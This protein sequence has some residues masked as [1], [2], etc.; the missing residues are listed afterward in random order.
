MSVGVRAIAYLIDSLLFA[1]GVIIVLYAFDAISVLTNA[2][3]LSY[4]QLVLIAGQCLYFFLWEAAVGW[5]PGKR[6]FQMRVV[7]LDGRPCGVSGSF[8]R[9]LIRPIDV[10]FFGLI[11]ALSIMS[12]FKRQRLGD[13]AAKTQVVREV[14]LPFVP[15]PYVPADK[16]QSRR[17]PRCGALAES[18]QSR[19]AVCDFD[20]DSTPQG[21]WPFG[22]PGFPMPGA[23]Q[24]AAGRRADSARPKPTTA[25]EEDYL[26]EEDQD[27]G[28]QPEAEEP[29]RRQAPPA[30]RPRAAAPAQVPSPFGPSQPAARART[31][32]LVDD[33]YD[34]DSDARLFAGR[35]ILMEGGSDEVRELARAVTEWEAA[36]RH[37]IVN[38]ARTLD[39]FRP[40]MVLEALRNDED[41]EVAAGA[42]DALATVNERTE[43]EEEER[44]AWEEARRTRDDDED[45]DDD[46]VDDDDEDATD[47]EDDEAVVHD[48][49]TGDGD[50]TGEEEVIGDEDEPSAP[51]APEAP[52]APQAPALHDKPTGADKPKRRK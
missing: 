43:R 3:G 29:A 48:D 52:E 27:E 42:R 22:V 20:L 32:G 24:G 25:E 12:G 40:Q 34:D 15:P 47:E 4:T 21:Q 19:C 14:P 10:L 50:V 39:G 38:V 7:R 37:F 46:G 31:A 35:E 13:R 18:G 41:E 6:V 51:P 28:E 30:A 16:P 5:T 26:E 44:L 49:T 11:G 8:V 33:L 1:F 45:D 23:R 9:N 36:D 2:R 17:C